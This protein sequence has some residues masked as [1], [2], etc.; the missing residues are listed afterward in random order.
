MPSLTQLMPV[1]DRD[2]SPCLVTSR[3]DE[4]KRPVHIHTH[5]PRT[6][7][8]T[9]KNI[10]CFLHQ[11]KY[12]HITIKV[13]VVELGKLGVELDI[14]V[15]HRTVFSVVENFQDNITVV[16]RATLEHCGGY[17]VTCAD[18]G[19]NQREKSKVSPLPVSPYYTTL[20]SAQTHYLVHTDPTLCGPLTDSGCMYA[21]YFTSMVTLEVKA[22]WSSEMG[23][24][25]SSDLELGWNLEQWKCEMG[26]PLK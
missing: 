9:Y 23:V 19:E 8:N 24:E 26:R 12:N 21:S 11:I 15:V 7:L 17:T 20:Y 3:T 10:K 5:T 6:T 25:W 13:T 22:E 16:V 4:H 1:R 18:R 14:S 2:Q